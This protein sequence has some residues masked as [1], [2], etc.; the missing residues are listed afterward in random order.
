MLVNDM[1]PG[2]Q[3]VIIDEGGKVLGVFSIEQA[4]GQARYAN[5][6]LV[7]VGDGPQGPVCK[8]LDYG[9]LVY[10]LRKK[11]SHSKKNQ[12]KSKVKE[13]KLRQSIE[14][15]DYAHKV[16]QIRTFL[17]DRDKVKVTLR[18]HGREHARPD[19]GMALMQKIVDDLDGHTKV[20]VAPRLEGSQ[21]LMLLGP[22]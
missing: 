19:L 17:E 7:K 13:I 4:L 21:I 16:D 18:F 1:I 6:D 5:L 20:E 8:I 11:A 15:G 2:P 9:K 22:K 10:A 3:V 12:K 14:K